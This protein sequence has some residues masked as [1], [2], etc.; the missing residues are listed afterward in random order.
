MMCIIR[1]IVLTL[2][3]KDGLRLAGIQLLELVKMLFG[4]KRHVYF[5]YNATTPIS[6]SV[7]KKIE[8][9]LK[10][11]P[12]NP[13]SLHDS[14]QKAAEIIDE[15]RRNIADAI[16]ADPLEIIFTGSASESNN[17]ILKSLFDLNYP[18]KR[19]IIC[20]PI[21]HP[22]VIK[23]LEYLQ[24]KG[25][26]I[27]YCP[28][29]AHG[30][31]KFETFDELIDESTFLV[32]CM[33]ANNEIGTIQDV[34][35]VAEIA[36]KKNV[37]V[38]SDCVQAFGKIPIDVV[39]LGVAY[40]SFSAH[41]VYGPKGTGVLYVKKGSS[42]SPLIHGGHQELGNR[43]G[44]EA[45]HNIAG[46]GEAS[47]SLDRHVAHAERLQKFKDFFVS[48]IKQIK[49]DCIVNSP[50]TDCLSNT[51]SLRF[52]GVKNENILA[53]LNY[54][55]IEVSAG[56]ACS[57]GD[58][59][60]S[61]VL[62]AIGLSDEEARET[63]RFSMGSN[64]S[65]KD[66]VYL[67]KVLDNYFKGK[68]LFVNRIT[69]AQLNKLMLSDQNTFVL[70]IRPEFQRKKTPGHKSFTIMHYSAIEKNLHCIPRDKHVVVACETG[71]L[72]LLAAYTL[73]S[74]GYGF[75]SSLKDGIREWN[76]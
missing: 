49:P 4:I 16:H 31:I 58:D 30:R 37:P 20:L 8:S 13:S 43:A 73:K 34:R 38:F 45:V 70:D 33:L 23:T 66:V 15:A 29:D 63:I 12:G 35:Q 11:F 65:R 60:P 48:G 22:S 25:L 55:G 74:K 2:F 62:K 44:T 32:C 21:E 27:Q 17:M 9:V 51:I 76:A 71:K 68:A 57:S 14:G 26:T 52:S 18:L 39:S 3:Q 42:I 47:L 46:F 6:Q 5:D 64:T 69:S 53:M 7:Q 54:Y 24:T 10:R 28:I 40:A 59:K 75:V 1:R 67:L 61:Y 50:E 41:K 19:K 72:S 36:L 56:S